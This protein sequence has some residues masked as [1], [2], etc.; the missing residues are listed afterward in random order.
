MAQ[1]RARGVSD[2]DRRNVGSRSWGVEKSLILSCEVVRM[3][4]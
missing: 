1:S 3:A 2:G 4:I